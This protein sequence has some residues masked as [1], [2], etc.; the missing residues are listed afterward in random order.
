MEIF[1]FLLEFF[2]NRLGIFILGVALVIGG[3]YGWK[4]FRHE[5]G[6]YDAAV[7]KNGKEV[8]AKIVWK[9]TE[10]SNSDSYRDDG[11]STLVGYINVEFETENGRQGAKVYLDS[12]EYDL[13]KEGDPIKIHY[14]PDNPEYVVTPLMKR[15]SVLFASIVTGFCMLLGILLCLAVIIS[16]F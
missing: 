14:H 8:E 12:S 7:G 13:V 11:G 15:S 5:V 4:E 3:I 1:E 2:F 9:N 6:M 10:R 16:L